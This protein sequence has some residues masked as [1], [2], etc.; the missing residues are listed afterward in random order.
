MTQKSAERR[1]FQSY[2]FRTKKSDPACNSVKVFWGSGSACG[3]LGDL[4]GLGL[5]LSGSLVSWVL[6]V[7]GL[8]M[9]GVWSGLSAY[10]VWVWGESGGFLSSFYGTDLR[11]W[12]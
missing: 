5:S 6:G 1:R 9:Y 7:C 10:G 2:S 11:N 4:G 12:F 8:H 3:V